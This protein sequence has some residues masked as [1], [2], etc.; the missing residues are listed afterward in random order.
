[1]V[2]LHGRNI[3]KVPGFTEDKVYKFYKQ[4]ITPEDEYLSDFD[5]EF[6]VENDKGRVMAVTSDFFDD[7]FEMM[8]VEK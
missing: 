1:M 5:I 3:N 6:Y 2:I 4:P 7:N 8:K